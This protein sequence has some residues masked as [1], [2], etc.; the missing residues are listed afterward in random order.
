M[1]LSDIKLYALNGLA[2]SITLT[3]IEPLLKVILL[4]LSIGYTLMRI[5]THLKGSTKN[6][7]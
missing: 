2:L 6:K 5:F 3:N 1:G 4:L 7:K